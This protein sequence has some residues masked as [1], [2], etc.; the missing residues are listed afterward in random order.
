MTRQRETG[1]VAAYSRAD[2]NAYRL[3]RGEYQR[4]LDD[5]MAGKAFF[6][7]CNCYGDVVSL[8]L[9]D[10]VAVSYHTPKGLAAARADTQADER[11]DAIDG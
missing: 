2:G 4:L 3:E 6:T 5:W 1:F 7:G 11:E 9:G 10:I 8:K